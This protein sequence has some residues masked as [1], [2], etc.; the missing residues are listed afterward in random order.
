MFRTMGSVDVL[1]TGIVIATNLGYFSGK[2][3]A[4]STLIS[5]PQNP[6]QQ[7][8]LVEARGAR[9]LPSQTLLDVR[10][11]K[12]IT[13]AAGRRID[14]L[15]DVLNVLNDTAAEGLVTDNLSSPNFGKPA[16]FIDPRRA[17]IS[18]RMNLGR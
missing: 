5:V 10:L 1:K 15:L 7:R 12:A 11:S 6:Q 3:W 14:L 17:M 2:S 8:V 16:S 9:Q 4:A 13:F 18:V